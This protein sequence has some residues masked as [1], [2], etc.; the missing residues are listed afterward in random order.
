M[1][2]SSPRK[3]QYLGLS[4]ALIGAASVISYSSISYGEW[5]HSP[6]KMNTGHQNVRCEYCHKES[7]GN[8]RQQ[9]QANVQYYL[10]YRSSKVNVGHL[11][12]DNSSCLS[13]HQYTKDLHPAYRFLEPRFSDARKNVEAHLCVSCHGEH[14][15]VRATAK[16]EFCKTCHEKID[17]KDDPIDVPHK[18]LVKLDQWETCMGCHDYHGNHKMKLV[19]ELDNRY[20]KSEILLHLAGGTE[21]YSSDKFYKAKES[22]DE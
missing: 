4:I 21:L 11:P 20:S 1:F 14:N 3:N 9:I 22:P 17:L 2:F 10:G 16:I 7:I 19:E 18:Y 8:Y 12:V 13:C 15:G 5:F 6:G